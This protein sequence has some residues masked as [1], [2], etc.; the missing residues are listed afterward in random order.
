[1]MLPPELVNAKTPERLVTAKL[2]VV[3]LLTVALTKVKFC[4]VDDPVANMF[5]AVSNELTK[6]LV[7]VREEEKKLVDVPCVVV[8]CNPVKFCRVVEPTTRRSPEELMVVVAV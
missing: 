1:M 6:E 5:A 2:V 3:A 4:K 8:D 7:E